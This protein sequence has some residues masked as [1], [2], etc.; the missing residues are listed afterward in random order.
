MLDILQLLK[1]AITQSKLIISVDKGRTLSDV[2][3]QGNIIQT[4]PLLMHGDVT[5]IIKLILN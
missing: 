2:T 5:H 3:D 1:P 4:Y